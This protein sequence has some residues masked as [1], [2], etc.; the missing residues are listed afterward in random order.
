[1]LPRS[2][3]IRLALA[4]ALLLLYT[5]QFRLY[6]GWAIDDPWISFQYARHLVEGKG[7]VF[8][9]GER[10]E[11]Y[12]NFLWVMQ[13]AA[14]HAMGFDMM[15]AA[16][17]LGF[18]FGLLPILFMA[19]TSVWSGLSSVRGT[20]AEEAI[21]TSH[22]LGGLLLATS[23]MWA[24]WAAGGLES[25]QF[26][27]LAALAILMLSLSVQMIAGFPA[28]RVVDPRWPSRLE[29]FFVK[30]AVPTSLI[31]LLTALSRPE[32]AMFGCI[33]MMVTAAMWGRY[34]G[35]TMLRP[36]VRRMLLALVFYFLIPFAA[37]TLWRR[38]YFGQWL[39]NTYYAKAV[40]PFEAQVRAGVEYLIK[41]LILFS[42]PVFAGLGI[43]IFTL[44]HGSMKAIKQLSGM[45]ILVYLLFIVK[46]GGDWMP[47]GRFL[48]HILPPLAFVAGAGFFYLWKK[49]QSQNT[50]MRIGVVALLAGTVIIAGAYHYR[51]TAPILQRVRAGAF[52]QPLVTAGQWLRENTPHDAVIAG[53]EAGIIPFTSRRRFIDML[54]IVD[55]H[56]AQIKG[57]LHQKYDA[58]YV[59]GREPD[60]ILLHV[61]RDTGE[62][63]YDSS[64]DMLA[65]P[66]FRERYAEAHRVTIGLAELA[67]KPEHYND[68][69]IYQRIADD[70]NAEND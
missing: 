36:H 13:M 44:Q 58:A 4:G 53:E 55:P 56:I 25:V 11:G 48:V 27:G 16:K 60:F 57:A 3:Y 8:N 69:V 7:L 12:S 35:D 54:G 51:E 42:L 46:V 14:A 47:M 20:K 1:M 26:A 45:L 30:S 41:Y 6:S 49:A 66:V 22:F 59:L 19:A 39:P 67:D 24:F 64:R 34:H 10:V 9:P 50:A 68:L 63:V 37:Y 23:G 32:G 21:S 38:W 2:L 70:N 43:W 61:T 40:A 62:G 28:Q 31:M 18:I 15:T 17:T 5:A 52:W 29:M 65:Q 33:A